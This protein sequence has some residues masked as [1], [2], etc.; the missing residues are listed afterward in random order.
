[1]AAC[2]NGQPDSCNDCVQV[3]RN[4]KTVQVPCTRNKCV[5]YT[6]KVPRQ[7][8]KQVPRTV[9]YTDF[10][11][12]Q[13]Q[14]P[15]TDYRSERRTRMETQKYQVPVTT[16]HIRMVP[17]TKKV[18]K[19]VYVDVTTQVPKTYQKTTMQTKERQVPVP[20]YVNVPETKY[21]TVTEQVPVQ[22]SKIQMDTVTKTVYDS[23]VR[24]RVVPET[25]IVTKQIPVYSVV[26]RPAPP[27]PPGAGRDNLAVTGGSNRTDMGGDGQVSCN[28]AA[29]GIDVGNQ[30]NQVSFGQYGNAGMTAQYGESSVTRE[31]AYDAQ[32]T[33]YLGASS[34]I[35]QSS[36]RQSCST[37]NSWY[38][39]NLDNQSGFSNAFGS[40]MSYGINDNAA[41]VNVNGY[42]QGDYTQAA[43]NVCRC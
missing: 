12:R 43:N 19:T 40:T 3:V 42:G 30:N 15:Y 24:T 6:V 33:G 38:G 14:V 36:Y 9:K 16:S 25:K 26:P 29:T 23:Q 28:E 18:P 39:Q 13:K 7:V 22:K 37:G 32:A 5:K 17:V 27:C 20:Y 8:T 10:E 4:T 34:G 1:M 2:G 31:A 41:A 35:G 11:S 21:R